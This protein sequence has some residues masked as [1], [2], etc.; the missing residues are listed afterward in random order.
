MLRK[1]SKF[2]LHQDYKIQKSM[3]WNK[4]KDKINKIV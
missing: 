2:K 1:F 3:K 4:Y